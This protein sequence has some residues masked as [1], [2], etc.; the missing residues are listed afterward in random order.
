MVVVYDDARAVAVIAL[1]D[2]VDDE[3]VAAIEK[4][5]SMGIEP[6]IVS[7]D[8]QAAVDSVAQ[9]V[10]IAE[11]H[12]A[13][14]PQEKLELVAQR[15]AAGRTVAMVG[16]GVND[17][18]ALAKAHLSMA[19]GAGADVAANSADIVLVRSSMAAAVDALRLSR[20]TMRTIRFN[21]L[22]AF[23]YNVA[24]IPLAMAG[25]LGPIVSAGTM[26]FSSVFVVTNSLRLRRFR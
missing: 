16:D 19:M 11:V 1:A 14:S 21:L 6:I 2:A 18:A 5:R 26:A 4:L 23:G 15:Q 10:G 7:G 3:S 9:A 22:W 12:A 25:V 24:A 17:A 13:C 20:A 8:H